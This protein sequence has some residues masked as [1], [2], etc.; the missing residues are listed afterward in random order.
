LHEAGKIPDQY[1][2]LDPGVTDLLHIRSPDDA[3]SPSPDPNHRIR[4]VVTGA[5][6]NHEAGVTRRTD[7]AKEW[8][9]M[10]NSEECN[11]RRSSVNRKTASLRR[12]LEYLVSEY[13][14][15]KET[16]EFHY[17][18]GQAGVAKEMTNKKHK[19]KW[20][21]L[22]ITSMKEKEKFYSTHFYEINRMVSKIKVGLEVP[23]TTRT[24]TVSPTAKIFYGGANVQLTLSSGGR[25]GGVPT[26]A[27]RR[28]SIKYFKTKI[29]DK[30]YTSQIC[31]DCNARLKKCI[32]K[33]FKVKGYYQE[34]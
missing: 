30:F 28:Q 10:A 24:L 19:F 25:R 23:N 16:R 22:M 5:Q 17:Y 2:G 34:I 9:R 15:D 26:K 33:M 8:M 20:R 32:N 12:T 7:L 18:Y 11:T 31:F 1:L 14:W 21:Y 29:V 27:F 6:F 4:Y 13:D 3:Q